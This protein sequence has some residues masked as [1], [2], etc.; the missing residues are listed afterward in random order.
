MLGL[1]SRTGADVINMA[2]RL[3]LNDVAVTARFPAGARNFLF[4][5]ASRYALRPSQPPVQICTEALTTSHSV[6]TEVPS[7]GLKSAGECSWQLTRT[8]MHEA[9]SSLPC[10]PSW[11]GAL[12]NGAVLAAHLSSRTY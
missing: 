5:T 9:M 1:L 3:R 11:R 10:T 6:H 8:K 4:F 12:R 7:H 2:A